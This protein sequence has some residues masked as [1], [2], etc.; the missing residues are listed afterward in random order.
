MRS[1]FAF[2]VW[3]L[4][5][6]V[7]YIILKYNNVNS[8]SAFIFALLVAYIFLI[9]CMQDTERCHRDNECDENYKHKDKNMFCLDIGFFAFISLLTFVLIIIYIF[10]KVFADRQACVNLL[11][12][13]N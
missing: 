11:H 13:H 12:A 2:L 8:W 6:I 4:I 5:L 7:V 9:V 3:F 1:D 10:Q